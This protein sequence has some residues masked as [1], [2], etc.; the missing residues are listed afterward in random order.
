MMNEWLNDCF[1]WPMVEIGQEDSD[2]AM[3]NTLFVAILRV[4]WN[5]KMSYVYISY[6][7]IH[8][9]CLYICVYIYIYT[10]GALSS[11]IRHVCG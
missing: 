11:P 5:A 8:E 2:S 4:A 6:T 9:N 7:Y 1:P 3:A 10:L